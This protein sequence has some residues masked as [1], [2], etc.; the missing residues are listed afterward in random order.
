M[1]KINN[2]I[3]KNLMLIIVIFFLFQPLIDATTFFSLNY[4]N[5]NIIVGTII[6][7]LF[8][9]FSLYYLIFINKDRKKVLIYL[10]ILTIYGGL[11][12]IPYLN[13]GLILLELKSFLKSYYFII[14]LIF[15][16][17]NKEKLR[18]TDYKYFN[19]IFFIY[20]IF[21]LVPNML[22]NFSNY[23]FFETNQNGLLYFT[24]EIGAIL[25]FLF[26]IYVYSM[27]KD[28]EKLKYIPLIIL[29]ICTILIIGTK[30]PVFAFIITALTFGIKY[31]IQTI[32]KKQIKQ[33]IIFTGLILILVTFSI[34]V[35]PKTSFYTNIKNH[36][37]YFNINS[38]KE[39]FTEYTNLDNVIFSERLTLAEDNINYY[40]DQNLY[41]KI[42]GVGL[43][44]IKD[45]EPVL[46]KMAEI[47]YIDIL[48]SYGILGTL[49]FFIPIIYALS[50]LIISLKNLKENKALYLTIVF[51]IFSI[52]LFS[53]HIFLIPAVSIYAAFFL[54]W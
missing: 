35:M 37:E 1:K 14:M 19:Y 50:N 20:I 22:N 34:I 52:A 6:R 21:M 40:K 3:E 24:N 38:T 23:K 54:S 36:M 43:Y 44:E 8:A 51:L 2:L 45:D 4:L 28:K 47:D 18:I 39:V 27:F 11:F 42:V 13:N 32:K 16:L 33:N 41:N 7:F 26:P 17:I 46:R 12:L 10:G 31:F 29:Y 15:F 9:G 53:G 30:V 49:L 48:V 25:S 5:I